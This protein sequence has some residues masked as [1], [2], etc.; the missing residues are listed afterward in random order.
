VRNR[1]ALLDPAALRLIYGRFRSLNW[2]VAACRTGRS[3][4]ASRTAAAMTVRQRICLGFLTRNAVHAG[5]AG[6]R[7]ADRHRDHNQPAV[8]TGCR[9][10][11]YDYTLWNPDCLSSEPAHQLTVRRRDSAGFAR[12][13]RKTPVLTILTAL[14]TV[15][16]VNT[17][18]PLATRK[19]RFNDIGLT[20]GISLRCDRPN[21]LDRNRNRRDSTWLS[22]VEA[23]VS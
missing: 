21:P 2:I 23:R 20:V 5:N 9:F 22:H 10:H 19:G 17:R 13:E 4:L 11:H 8:S 14:P 3:T 18:A 16:R 1:D 12:F 6:R 7:Q 15:R